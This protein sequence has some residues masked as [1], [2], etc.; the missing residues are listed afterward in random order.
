MELLADN[1]A[2]NLCMACWA[3]KCWEA[4]WAGNE[5]L[6]KVEAPSF[7]PHLSFSLNLLVGVV[8]Y[9]QRCLIMRK[10]ELPFVYI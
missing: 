3:L 8:S 1:I 5:P 4:R 7:C 9:S 2:S 6:W 10:K